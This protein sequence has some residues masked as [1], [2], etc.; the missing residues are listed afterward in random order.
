M[1]REAREAKGWTQK[2]VAKALDMTP[3]NVSL[4]EKGTVAS[5]ADRLQRYAA[6]VGCRISVVLAR[7]GERRAAAAAR[8]LRL[9]PL[10]DEGVFDTL[11]ASVALWEV[12]YATRAPAT[13]GLVVYE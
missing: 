5:P 13:V 7:A 3:Q 6:L 10:L 1:L 8:L 9:I 12:K 11:E 4:I 2:R